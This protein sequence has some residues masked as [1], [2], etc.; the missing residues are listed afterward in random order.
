[1]ANGYDPEVEN[2]DV[3]GSN[4]SSSSPG[5]SSSSTSG[6]GASFSMGDSLDPVRKAERSGGFWKPSGD[7]AGNSEGGAVDK[8]SPSS[9]AASPTSTTGP[10]RNAPLQRQEQGDGNDTVGSGYSSGNSNTTSK[11]RSK[12]K[13]TKK[14]AAVG[15]GAIAGLGGI[16]L[17]M[18]FLLIPLK[19]ESMVVNLEHRFFATAKNAVQKETD[20]AFRM[21]LKREIGPAL[22]KGDCRGYVSKDCTLNLPGNGRNPVTNLYKTWNQA[23][24]ENTLADKYGIELRFDRRTRTYY[25]KSPGLHGEAR[26]GN[27]TSGL[28][29][30]FDRIVN[31]S[32]IRQA[33]TD[34][35]EGMTKWDKVMFRYK[36]G[37]LLQEKYGVKRC[38]IFCG[39]KDALSD[40]KD[41]VL[42]GL[43]E[44]KAAAQIYL[45]QRVLVPLDEARGIALTCLISTSCDPT[46]TQPTTPA[47]GSEA[48]NGAPEDPTTDTA[49]RNKLVELAGKDGAVI[50]DALKELGKMRND[51]FTKYAITYALEKAGMSE[52]SSNVTDAV[53]IVGWISKGSAIITQLNNAGPIVKKLSYVTNAAG[54][55]NL[56]MMYR[57]YADEIHTGHVNATEVGSLV[58][59]LSP[60][61]QPGSSTDPQVGGTAGAEGS[62]LYGSL[63][64]SN[65]TSTTSSTSASLLGS[66]LP[67][68]AYAASSSTR[69]G[70]SSYK[71]ANGRGVPSGSLVCE[72]EKLGGGNSTLNSIHSFL[73]QGFIGIIT[74]AAGIIN[75]PLHLLGNILG[76]ILSHLPFINN[77]SELISKAIAPLFN[78]LLKDVIK[79]PF[80][81]KMSG[82]RSFNMVAAGADVS[83]ND[84]AHT[85]L[86][87]RKLSSGAVA[88]IVNEQDSQAKQQFSH[89]P[90]FA[91][92]FSTNSQ[93]SLVSKVAMDVPFGFQSTAATSFASFIS[94]P[95]G[96]LT[97]SFAS[98]FSGRASA[99]VT[100]QPDAFNVVQ[101]GY[102]NSDIP[103]DPEAYWNQHC[104]DGVNGA[105]TQQWNNDASQPSNLD[106][107]TQ[108]PVNNTTDPCLLI[109]STSGSAG[110]TS[111]SSLLTADEQA[112]LNASS[113]GS[114]TTTP[115]PSGG[116]PTG[117]AKDL[118][119]QL[120]PLIQQGKISCNN[121]AHDCPD[122]QNTAKGVSIKGGQGCQVD[123]LQPALLG[124]LLKLVQMGHTFVL[125]ALCSDHSNDGSLAGHSGGR[126]ADFN[127]IDG[128]FMG[129]NDVPWDSSKNKVGQKLDQD[130]ASFMPK[131]TG[132]GQIQCHPSYPFLSGFVTFSDTCH[133][134]HIQVE[135]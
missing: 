95:F 51:G 80:A 99:A 65:A 133:H 28:G 50:D 18:F 2:K 52:I 41:S 17:I 89:E 48:L 35:E 73:N 121:Q 5:A 34:A 43:T 9:E 81:S 60:G 98:I 127:Y 42:G 20:N 49:I 33:L 117:T 6:G 116:L 97:N 131:T 110:A 86:G 132:F 124:M 71:C 66:L 128:V 130:I 25:M 36:V 40:K 67:G 96:S 68:T 47:T 72:E 107:A 122:I 11:L 7:T 78:T 77:I 76:A 61:T 59:S 30:G 58:G 69:G 84:Y 87:G 115:T 29:S 64:G 125:S 26:V 113:P 114:Q 55:V 135:N 88:T 57:T 62:P 16:G 91:R 126:A 90:F 32:D 8:S 118:A 103:S 3:S 56:Y 119:S 31:R 38:I 79:T 39:V 15:G 23:K 129:P 1:M 45:V 12:I 10:G 19:I 53:P 112:N 105:V 70:S 120:L 13:V 106:P 63:M 22:A 85:G 102:S 27:A 111:D 108:T 123:G 21:F 104:S 37:T 109:S 93:Y 54:A 74:T 24:I 75:G 14:Q 82:A 83:G 134:Q 44:R 46:R 101:Y 94:N 4:S 92:M 100:A